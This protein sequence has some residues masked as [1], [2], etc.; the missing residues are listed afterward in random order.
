MSK[1]VE[2]VIGDIL[3]PQTLLPALEGVDWLFHT[4]AQSSLSLLRHIQNK[5]GARAAKSAPLSTSR[6]GRV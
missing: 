4:A 1:H 2:R 5:E 3:D 6:S